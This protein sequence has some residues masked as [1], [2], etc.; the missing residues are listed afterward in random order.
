MLELL[1]ISQ[2]IE[3]KDFHRIA[4]FLCLATP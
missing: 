4:L 1:A 2:E 3:D